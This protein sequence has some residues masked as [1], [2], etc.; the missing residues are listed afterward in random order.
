MP[1]F[2][3]NAAA[4]QMR[5]S[6]TESVTVQDPLSGKTSSMTGVDVE[7]TLGFGDSITYSIDARYQLPRWRIEASYREASFSGTWNLVHGTIPS[8]LAVKVDWSVLSFGVRGEIVSEPVFG[9][10][11]GLDVDQIR[12]SCYSAPVTSSG[13]S[14]WYR[15]DSSSPTEAIPY[16]FATLRDAEGRLWLDLEA[17]TSLFD[18]STPTQ[19]VRVEAGWLITPGF[20]LQAAW[21]TYRYR[22]TEGT[23]PNVNEVD[24]RVTSLTAGLTFRF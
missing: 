12:H 16:L 18:G 3:I 7:Q 10:G 21:D 23:S 1:G 13:S 2:Y 17:G 9:L 22:H 19:K 24:F 11:L 8:P 15:E 20:G 6:G 5:P 4:V 14:L